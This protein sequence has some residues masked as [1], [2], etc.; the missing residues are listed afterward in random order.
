MNRASTLREGRA[1]LSSVLMKSM[2]RIAQGLFLA[3]LLG[4]S[5][6]VS[7]PRGISVANL[8]P[9]AVPAPGE[10]GDAILPAGFKEIRWGASVEILHGVRGPMER[11]P[12]PKTDIELLIEAPQPGE[13]ATN[14]VHYKLW[15]DQLVELRIYYQERLSGP[16][17]HDFLAR[18]EAAYG[19]G[20][21]SS[22]RAPRG[23]DGML[24]PVL[25]ESWR[26]EDPFTTQILL[27]NPQTKEWSMLRRSRVLE[28]LRVATEEREQTEDRDERVKAMPID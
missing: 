8:T 14:I 5:L 17:A 28:E 22:R 27:R 10:G 26:W 25:E 3:T 19:E 12:S 20:L 1:S 4:A 11:R 9:S 7:Q 13:E 2:V 18:V 15:R 23:K 16:E 24:G 21:H 6:A